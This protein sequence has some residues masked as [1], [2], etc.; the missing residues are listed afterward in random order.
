LELGY[1]FNR[2]VSLEGKYAFGESQYTHDKAALDIAYLGV[3]IGVGLCWF[4][5]APITS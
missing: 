5:R 4:I 2:W 1:D 3:N